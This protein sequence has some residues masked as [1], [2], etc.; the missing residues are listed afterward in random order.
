MSNLD[1]DDSNDGTDDYPAGPEDVTKE[2][3]TPNNYVNMSMGS[4]IVIHGRA[5][6]ST[7]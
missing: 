1:Q 7:L 3:R 6:R 4:N 2:W 5:I